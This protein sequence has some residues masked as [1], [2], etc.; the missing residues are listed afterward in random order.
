LADETAILACSAYVDL[1]PVRAGVADPP[2]KSL[3]TSVYE[4]VSAEKAAQKEKAQAKIR[5][6][7]AGRN[8]SRSSE[9]Q[10]GYVRRDDWLTPLT[11]DERSIASKGAM[12]SKTG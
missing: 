10:V 7:R 12:P 8:R 1:N 6:R 3:Y 11:L 9:C 4:R 5:K 2:E